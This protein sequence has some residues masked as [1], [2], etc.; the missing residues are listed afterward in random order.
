MVLGL[1]MAEIITLLVFLLMLAFTA[2]SYRTRLSMSELQTQ[3]RERQSALA[4]ITKALKDAGTEVRP[5]EVIAALIV[6]GER[7]DRAEQER[8]SALA[9]QRT[10]EREAAAVKADRDRL[11]TAL[12][13]SSSEDRERLQAAL[14]A[15][16]SRAG[17]DAST[18]SHETVA[19]LVQRMDEAVA[20]RTSLGRETDVLRGQNEQLRREAARQRGQTGSGSP[21]CWPTAQG[22]PEFMLR[23]ILLDSGVLVRDR[24]PRSQPDDEAWQ[25][26]SSLPREEMMS[27]QAFNAAIAPLRAHGQSQRC[28]Y[29]V[30]ALDETGPTNKAGYK[31]LRGGLNASFYV[32]EVQR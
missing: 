22:Q 28:L 27:L 4:S 17:L 6:R 9:A 12:R 5:D 19:L 21:Y 18:P 2:V 7:V 15:G 24:S 3:L 16:R 20:A 32:R 30:E 13:A 23:I 8:D 26:I 10:A 14:E 1:T 11:A 31:T 25:L 29:A